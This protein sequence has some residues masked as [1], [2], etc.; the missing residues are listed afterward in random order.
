MGAS[1]NDAI[2]AMKALSPEEGDETHPGKAVRLIAITKGWNEACD[3]DDGCFR[4][5]S[6]SA[7]NDEDA[8][9]SESTDEPG[10]DDATLG[11]KAGKKHD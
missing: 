11:Y 6:A 1:R 4:D 7:D 8:P 10:A 3:E 2:A 9:D 5:P